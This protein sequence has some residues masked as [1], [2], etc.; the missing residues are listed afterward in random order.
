MP[1]EV[2]FQGNSGVIFQ[3]KCLN[4]PSYA[5]GPVSYLLKYVIVMGR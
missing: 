4:L 1:A 2:F 3:E 5:F